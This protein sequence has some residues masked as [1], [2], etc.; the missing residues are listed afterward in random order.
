METC[1]RS[2]RRRIGSGKTV[3]ISAA[4]ALF[5]GMSIFGP[6]AQAGYIDPASTN[7]DCNAT[8]AFTLR[9]DCVGQVWDPGNDVGNPSLLDYLNR[10]D[11]KFIGEDDKVTP[12]GIPGDWLGIPSQLD[13][14]SGDIPGSS[15]PLTVTVTG[16]NGDNEPISG[17]WTFDLGG[18][19]IDYLVI[20]VKNGGGW[21]S[22]FYD[23]TGSIESIFSD[24]WDT[25]GITTGPKNASGGNP[26]PGVSHMFAAYIPGTTDP[27]I[28]VPAPG[29]LALLGL[30]LFSLR[31]ARRRA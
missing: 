29:T 12:W 4:A 30:G 16:T 31:W 1:S 10:L 2:P 5:S 21:S 7:H 9:T 6:P 22:Y 23:L 3:K 28:P 20:N 26:G 25:L 17:G 19:E 14:D 24:T 15:G 18:V 11:G 27:D 13:A 8:E